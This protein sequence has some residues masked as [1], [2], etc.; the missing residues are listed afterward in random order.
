MIELL[1]SIKLKIITLLKTPTPILRV[2]SM[3]DG[4]G[5]SSWTA[6]DYGY[7]LWMPNMSLLY[8]G[9]I[10]ILIKQS[11]HPEKFR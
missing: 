4:R 1:P 2:H 3:G 9:V 7:F 5:S 10:T 8:I 6:I 11:Y